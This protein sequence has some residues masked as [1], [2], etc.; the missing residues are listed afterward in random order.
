M[1][2]QSIMFE[3]VADCP[4]CGAAVA[5]GGAVDRLVCT[6]CS[7]VEPLRPAF[8]ERVLGQAVAESM[9]FPE[10]KGRTGLVRSTPV[11]KIVYGRM[12]PRCANCKEALPTAPLV[13]AAKEGA[14]KM[15]CPHC[16]HGNT[17]RRVPNWFRSIHPASVALV[18]EASERV[19]EAV[20]FHCFSCGALVPAD[21]LGNPTRCHTCGER[22][23]IPG[24]IRRRLGAP[25]SAR[26]RFFVLTDM[27]D[28]VGVLPQGAR[29]VSDFG[30]EPYGRLVLAWHGEVRPNLD[31]RPRLSLVDHRGLVLWENDALGF[32]DAVRIHACPSSGHIVL[33]DP[34]GSIFHVDPNDGSLVQTVRSDPAGTRLNV[35]GATG[36]EVDAD[37]S[38][39]V[40]RSWAPGTEP[41]LRRFSEDGSALP[42]WT[43]QSLNGA[44]ADPGPAPSWD[45]LP[46]QP[47]RLP[48]GTFFVVGWD[49]G[50]YLGERQG[51]RV[52]RYDRQGNLQGVI[53][54]D[55][56]VIRE[57]RSI[58]AD[59]HGRLLILFNHARPHRAALY[60]HVGVLMPDGRL[61]LLVGPHASNSM[62]ETPPD[63]GWL[64][65]MPD[66]T[67]YLGGRLDQLRIIST[68]GELRWESPQAVEQKRR[69][70][71]GVA[72]SGNLWG[73]R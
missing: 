68:L 17:V 14:D 40:Y 28:A 49:G 19:P 48:A 66:G 67:I 72:R 71:D 3:V 35:E 46:H 62:F 31:P 69:M 27:G 39:V 57:L 53:T 50:F 25:T 64:K 30:I 37:G 51:G 54:P 58:G 5:L 45:D 4:S 20:R 9:S 2:F 11:V 61:E 36:F 60:D 47:R 8:W 52:A 41:S 26:T 15:F 6:R 38:R 16:G 70:A 7:H 32:S 10:G 34:A 33:V 21:P 29:W 73:A 43:G 12:A 1:A 22:V 56:T 42:L 55:S 59:A 24:G 63:L 65:L 23:S 13:E 18:G 44:G